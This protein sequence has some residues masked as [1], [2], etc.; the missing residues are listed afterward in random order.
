MNRTT[1]RQIVE[2]RITCL[3]GDSFQDFCDRLC[4]KLHRG[5]YTPVRA[6]GPMGDMKNDGYCPK[7]RIFFAA[8]ATIGE[9]ISK[10]TAKIQED[11]E[12]CIKKQSGVKTW[13]FLTNQTLPGEAERFVDKLRSRHPELNIETWG[14]K[15]IAEKVLAFSQD[16]VGEIIDMALEKAITPE[17][18]EAEIDKAEDLNKK[19][20][21]REALLCLELLWGRHEAEMSDRQKYRTK[22]SIGHAY[23]WLEQFDKAAKCFLE[24][25]QFDPTYPNAREREAL[26][27]LYL[28]KKR[29]AHRLATEVLADFPG[30]DL[31]RAVWI[32]T[33]PKRLKFKQLEEKVPK[34]QRKK[35]D[36]A[37]ALARVGMSEDLF[38]ISEKYLLKVQDSVPQNP[39]LT[40]ILGDL[41]FQR[42][43]A[44]ELLSQ[45]RSP[46][47]SEKQYLQK[48][49]DSFK[50]S[51]Q[52]WQ[53]RGVTSAVVRVLLKRASARTTLG[54]EES[55]E[56]DIKMAY[57]LDA[58]NPEA[59]FHYA[60][61]KAKNKDYSGAIDHLDGLVGKVRPSV[62]NLL[63][64]VLYERNEDGDKKRAV[65]LL[66]SRLKDLKT[67]DA[68]L[69]YDYLDMLLVVEQE[70]NGYEEALVVLD[71]N[72]KQLVSNMQI[73]ILRGR[74]LKRAG[75][76]PE[77]ME[78][79]RQALAQ[80]N[81]KTSAEDRRRIAGIL[82]WVGLYKEALS[83]W[84]ELVEP[85]YIGRDT[86]NLLDCALECDDHQFIFAFC[87]KLGANELWDKRIF[88]FELHFREKYNDDPG[89]RKVMEKFLANPADESYAPFVRVR[90][91]LL[92][93]RTGR[94]ELIETDL[95]KLPLVQE[96][97]PHTG[98]AVVSILREGGEPFRAVEYAYELVRLHW[99][100][101]EAHLAMIGAVLQIKGPA[102]VFDTPDIVA[103]GVA[104]HYQED[105]TG[106]KLWHIIEDS[107]ESPPD[108]ARREFSAD[109]QVTKNVLSKKRGDKFYLRKDD[110]GLQERTATILEIAS[111]YLYRYSDCLQ[112]FEDR[113][114]STKGIQKSIAIKKDG[115]VDITEMKRLV[116]QR[117]K[118]G[119]N[120]EELYEKEVVPL[121]FVAEGMGA[122]ILV[123]MN[124]IASKSGLRLRC[125]V[126]TDEEESSAESGIEKA[127]EIV[128][129]MSALVTLL[130]ADVYEEIGNFP[131]RCI[132]S[133][134]TLRDLR[135]V[136][137]L[138]GNP[139]SRSGFFVKHGDDYIMVED[140]PEAIAKEKKKING[141]I[142][143]IE[144]NCTVESGLVLTQLNKQRRDRLTKLFGQA[145]LESMMLAAQGERVLWTDDLATALIA[146]KEM[147]CHR[148][149][150]QFIFG[151]L[152]DKGC[153][154]RKIAISVTLKLL[155]MEYYYTK[156]SAGVIMAA[157]EEVD[158]DVDKPPLNQALN[159]FSN[160]NVKVEGLL[161]IGAGVVKQV[162]QRYRIGTI[163]QEIT[164]RIL[165][166]LSQINGG[167]KV[168]YGL[169]QNADNIFT[170]DVISADRFKQVID[171]WLK[172]RGGG[173]IIRP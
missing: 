11:L 163:A 147:G 97:D 20:K 2:N 58:D 57:E 132:V 72:G 124:H 161:Y 40:E 127:K 77:A 131:V 123:T 24:A 149:W 79:T 143:L 150:S 152:A 115:R 172:S 138:I 50:E 167:Y 68:N 91:S 31:A 82:Q 139:E 120:L 148:I 67:E 113:F 64:K 170:V 112:Q 21:H 14:H 81:K 23:D 83:F 173:W 92:G 137:D 19:G 48:A 95:K 100:N 28:G 142:D 53:S 166:R 10:T 17:E 145:G 61:L 37:I 8:H 15:K 38:E 18:L 65:E 84:K 118:R 169:L 99:N 76:N 30:Q 162:W 98:R 160:E 74:I 22:G 13:V 154:S 39:R 96:V 153:I 55:G 107:E 151:H 133:V 12:G 88:E 89:A 59:V 164:I 1:L 144:N 44:H 60:I 71:T 117:V 114:G 155:Q 85:E 87:E 45:E 119:L 94:K 16:I 70:T 49:I 140:S 134:G 41:M 78:N 46:T 129:D 90:L 51:L 56:F 34:R 110:S 62:E 103:K 171:G 101:D 108:V 3:T 80:I 9:K 130:F 165:E 54:D 42:V 93:A 32:N 33:A 121:F 116:D 157:V 36:V 7:A 4:L 26:A 47:A 75:K 73:L 126:G 43:S 141:L 104:V 168:I 146:C 102:V 86:Y 109:H 156:P 122:S 6:G 135:Q 69:R 27:Y 111:K 35:P 25:Y 29:K 5:D 125:C 136:V 159:W 63:A 106:R 105:D 66:K 52:G 158:G 128:L